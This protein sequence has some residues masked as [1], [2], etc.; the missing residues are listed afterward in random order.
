MICSLSFCCHFPN[1]CVIFSSWTFYVNSSR[2]TFLA[3]LPCFGPL[4]WLF[5]DSLNCFLKL[6]S[7]WKEPNISKPVRRDRGRDSNGWPRWPVREVADYWAAPVGPFHPQIR[8]RSRSTWRLKTCE[9]CQFRLNLLKGGTCTLAWACPWK[10]TTLMVNFLVWTWA[11]LM[12]FVSVSL[13]VLTFGA[14]MELFSRRRYR[15]RSAQAF[16][17]SQ[18]VHLLRLKCS[19][20]YPPKCQHVDFW[21]WNLPSLVW[22]IAAN[23][24]YQSPSI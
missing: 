5:R 11:S 16:M 24:I 20:V 23:A 9:N 13:V 22:L 12:E 14:P 3:I 6:V 18:K 10:V 19:I 2:W 8:F 1:F 4:K 17:T 21:F 7:S 15:L